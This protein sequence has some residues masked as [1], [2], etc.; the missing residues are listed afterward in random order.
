MS[1][2]RGENKEK[3]YN[4]MLV[5]FTRKGLLAIGAPPKPLDE[6]NLRDSWSPVVHGENKTQTE[7]CIAFEVLVWNCS[8]QVEHSLR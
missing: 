2:E 4:C 5:C 8:N 3:I 1:L 7:E 6:S